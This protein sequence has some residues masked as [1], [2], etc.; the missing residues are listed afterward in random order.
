LRFEI[1]R[2]GFG[3]LAQLA[4]APALHAGGRRFESDILHHG[5]IK[6][7]E[8]KKKIEIVQYIE[9]MKDERLKK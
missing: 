6:L 1:F 8:R 5:N 9:M 7:E 2:N 4:R 3:G